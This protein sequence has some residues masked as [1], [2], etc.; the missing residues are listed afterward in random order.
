MTVLVQTIVK[1]KLNVLC[2][3][4]THFFRRVVATKKSFSHTAQKYIFQFLSFTQTLTHA[5]ARR[6]RKTC[7]ETLCYARDFPQISS[8][9]QRVNFLQR[10][11]FE[12]RQ[13]Q[14]DSVNSNFSIRMFII[15]CTLMIPGACE[16]CIK[17]FP[18]KFQILF[19]QPITFNLYLLIVEIL[20][21]NYKI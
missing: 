1:T 15:A 11:T 12:C 16:L 10:I 20:S 17:Y 8:A 21:Q 7:T 4:I 14:D 2:F 13:K 5:G 6:G 18:K 3:I 9:D 19:L